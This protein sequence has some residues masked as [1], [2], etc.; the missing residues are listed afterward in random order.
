VGEGKGRVRTH[1]LHTHARQG[2]QSGDTVRDDAGHAVVLNIDGPEAGEWQEREREGGRERV[3]V[4]GLRMGGW[5]GERERVVVEGVGMGGWEGRWGSVCVCMMDLNSK[6]TTAT[7]DHSNSRNRVPLQHLW[8]NRG[9]R[10][11][12]HGKA[13]TPQGMLWSMGVAK[14]VCACRFHPLQA[15]DCEQLRRK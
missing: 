3:V 12:H 11:Q 2:R 6:N 5:E 15:L 9:C 10:W 1:H 4:E 7:G 14:C 13:A 8:R